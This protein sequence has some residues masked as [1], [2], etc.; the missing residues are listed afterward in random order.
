MPHILL[1]ALVDN[2][3]KAEFDSHPVIKAEIEALQEKYKHRGR[4]LVR[5][6]GTE[7]KVRVMIEGRDGE[8]IREDA[9][10]VVK[11]IEMILG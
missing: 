8:M 1:F 9:E 10:R 2:S 3:K 11:M 7:P 4:V 5:A 6:S